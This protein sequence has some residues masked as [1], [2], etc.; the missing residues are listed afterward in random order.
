[1]LKRVLLLKA[2]GD[3]AK[4]DVV[5]VDPE[6]AKRLIEDGTGMDEE[7]ALLHGDPTA[8]PPAGVIHARPEKGKKRA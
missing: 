5:V 7:E 2:W 4:G 1:M 3:F 8:A 6:R